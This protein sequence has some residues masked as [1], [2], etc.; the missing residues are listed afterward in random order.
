[1]PLDN[2]IVRDRYGGTGV[3]VEKNEAIYDIK[4]PAARFRIPVESDIF[5]RGGRL[6]YRLPE[7]RPEEL[8]APPLAGDESDDRVNHKVIQ[9]IN[10]LH[11]DDGIPVHYPE[12]VSDTSFDHDKLTR[13][14]KI[15]VVATLMMA[16][17]IFLLGVLYAS[18]PNK[19]TQPGTNPKTFHSFAP[20]L[21]KHNKKPTNGNLSL[22]TNT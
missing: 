13:K 5:M 12:V 19:G 21:K 15:G 14:R 4:T 6:V 1:M 22:K 17:F 20:T 10:K 9:L 11:A 7:P 2:R 16:C 3:V 8:E 18:L